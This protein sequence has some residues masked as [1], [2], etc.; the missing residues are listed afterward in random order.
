[1]NTLYARDPALSHCAMYPVFENATL[2]T[3]VGEMTAVD[4]T[5]GRTASG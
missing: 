4:V 3:D 2:L 1:M 5:I